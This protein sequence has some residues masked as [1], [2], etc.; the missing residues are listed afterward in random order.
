MHDPEPESTI[1][2]PEDSF[3]HR[4]SLQIAFAIEDLSQAAFQTESG[5]IVP[6]EKPQHRQID[7]ELAERSSQRDC[8]LTFRCATAR[9]AGRLVI[10]TAWAGRA[11]RESSEVA[12]SM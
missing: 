8:Y 5:R 9:R 3:A 10:G 6:A 1:L 12:A 4:G 7:L 11:V 2:N